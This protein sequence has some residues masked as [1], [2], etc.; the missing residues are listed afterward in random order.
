M[1]FQVSLG[2]KAMEASF[3]PLEQ[4]NFQR[5]FNSWSP[6]TLQTPM[7]MWHKCRHLKCFQISDFPFSYALPILA[8]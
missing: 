7:N 2:T 4:V 3:I 5:V 8:F 1:H 6:G